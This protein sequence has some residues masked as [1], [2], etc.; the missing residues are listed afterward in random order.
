M[1]MIMIAITK[2]NEWS[3]DS[4]AARPGTTK[5]RQYY[6]KKVI[7]LYDDD[8]DD[9]DHDDDDDDT[10]SGLTFHFRFRLPSV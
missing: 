7:I 9:D 8:D 5:R 6:Y 1:I 10:V 3:G 2:G 4:E